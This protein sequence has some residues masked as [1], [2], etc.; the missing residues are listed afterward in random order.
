MI[1]GWRKGFLQA[2]Y[3]H[4]TN[5]AKIVFIIRGGMGKNAIIPHESGE[6]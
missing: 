4:G 3:I 5:I 6:G 2:S 1:N